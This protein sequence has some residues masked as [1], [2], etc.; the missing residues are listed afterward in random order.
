MLLVKYDSPRGRRAE[1]DTGA[2]NLWRPIA[3]HAP[4]PAAVVASGWAQGQ[5]TAQAGPYP[6]PPDRV[7][8][9][10]SGA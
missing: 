5:L 10:C 6:V 3:C 9:C 8:P 1:A 2:E 7:R 4:Y